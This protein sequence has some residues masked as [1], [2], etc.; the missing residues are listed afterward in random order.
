MRKI[1]QSEAE[2]RFRERNFTLLSLYQGSK[3]PVRAR[4]C[5]GR[6][7]SVRPGA[8]MGLGIV[9]RRR[10]GKNSVDTS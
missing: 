2:R 6:V 7:F 4:C 5:C 10:R 9:W 8:S 1:T 3:I